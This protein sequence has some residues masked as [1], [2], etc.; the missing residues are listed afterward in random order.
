MCLPAAALPAMAIAAGVIQGAGSLYSGMAANAQ[1]K[2]E[3]ELAERNAAME[4]EA[5]HESV[6]AGRDERT[7]F[8]RKVSQVKGQQIAAMAANGIDVGYGTADLIQQDTQMLANE[9]AKNLYRNIDERTRGHHINAMNF[10]SESKAARQRGKAALVG[11]VFSAASSVLGG[12]QQ[13][14]ALRPKV[15]NPSFGTSY[16]RNG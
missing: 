15:E 11:S 2:Y 8:W 6:L 16:S 5:A 14:S 13:A 4:V 1:G 12:A 7:A 3:S 9:D 10:V